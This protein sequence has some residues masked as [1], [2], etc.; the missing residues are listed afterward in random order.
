MCYLRCSSYSYGKVCKAV[1]GYYGCDK[2]NQRG[3]WDGRI[4]YPETNNLAMRTDQSFR[5]CWQ[6]EH[7]QEEEISPF[8]VLPIDM[9][10]SF[11]IDYMHQSCLGVMKKLLLLWTRGRTDF[12][13]SSG[14]VTRVSGR[15]E[16]LKKSIPDCFARKPR[17]LQEIDRWK[18]TE[19]RQFAIYTGKIVLKGILQEQLYEH[20]LSKKKNF[21]PP[22]LERHHRQIDFLRTVNHP[23]I[24]YLCLRSGGSLGDGIRRMLKK[25]GD[26]SLWEY[27]SY[28]GRKGKLKFQQLLINDVIIRACSKAYPNQKSQSVEDMIAVTLKHAP[29]REKTVNQVR[30]QREEQPS[31]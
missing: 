27:Y 7:H 2:C 30:S 18:A 6:P 26:N 19:F 23:K 25:I 10:K 11:P 8:S 14:D 16:T 13:I 3:S 31:E 4:T 9:I 24:R 29:D 5:E 22:N 15:L 20:F 12:R 1:S 17:S 21:S 28:K